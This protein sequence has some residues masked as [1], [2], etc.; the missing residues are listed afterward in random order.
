M[1]SN[2]DTSNVKK[3]GYTSFVIGILIAVIIIGGGYVLYTQVISK[4]SNEN[5]VNNSAANSNQASLPTTRDLTVQEKTELG[6]DLN[7]NATVTTVNINGQTFEQLDIDEATRPA[8]ADGDRLSDA[9]EKKYGTD[10]DNPDTDGDGVLDSDEIRG[11]GTDP[12]K[13]D[14]DGDGFSDMQEIKAGYNPN[15]PGTLE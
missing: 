5:T 11:W 12:L 9:D 8:D 1:D 7:I 6:Y 14:T 13:A 15:G 4:P 3:K 2:N 10:A